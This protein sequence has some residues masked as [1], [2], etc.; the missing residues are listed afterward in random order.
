MSEKT[1]I[2][3]RNAVYLLHNR[4]IN[5]MNY[6][7]FKDKM[8]DLACFSSHQVYAWQPEFDRNNFSR[9]IK[10]GLMVRLRRGYYSFPEYLNKP[11]FS[12][13]FANRIYR[14]SYISLHSALAF[15]GIIPEAVIQITSVTTLKTINFKNAVGNYTYKSVRDN[16]LFGYDLK[17]IADGRTL[18][19]AKPEKALLDLLYLYPFYKSASD[20]EALRL[21]EDFMHDEFDWELMLEYLTLF[22]NKTLEKRA[23]IL[24]NTYKQ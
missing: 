14:P 12:L 4:N 11:D 17:P 21:D 13:Y 7:E 23:K 9:W 8:F 10:R 19:L 15:Y 20:M 2:C 24:A 6:I 18:Q 16:L 1:C 5:E 3:F 22:Q